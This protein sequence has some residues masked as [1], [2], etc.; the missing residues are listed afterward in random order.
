MPQPATSGA[1]GLI[2]RHVQFVGALRAAGLP[3]SMAE[4]LDATQAMATV[5]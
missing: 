2:D 5:Q 1:T 4:S 3:V